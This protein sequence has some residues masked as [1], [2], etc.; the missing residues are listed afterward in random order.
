MLHLDGFSSICCYEG[1]VEGNNA[2]ISPSTKALFDVEA[3]YVGGF[4]GSVADAGEY[5][6]PV[7]VIYAPLRVADRAPLVFGAFLS[8]SASPQLSRLLIE[9]ALVVMAASGA[10]EKVLPVPLL[11]AMA[12]MP[13]NL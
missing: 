5:F 1:S 12:A 8:A 7:S 3:E 11:L 2:D 4:P 10:A 13:L 6:T 9:P